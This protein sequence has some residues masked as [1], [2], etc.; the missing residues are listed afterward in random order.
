MW[1]WVDGV[2]VGR[3][4]GDGVGMGWKGGRVGISWR[5]KRGG[6]GWNSGGNLQLDTQPEGGLVLNLNNRF[7]PNKLAT[8]NV[9]VEEIFHTKS[10]LEF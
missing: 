2:L 7:F 4:S 8:Q 3:S 6:E 1:D 9:Q 5:G 10:S